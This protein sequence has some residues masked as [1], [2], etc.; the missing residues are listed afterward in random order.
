MDENEEGWS[1]WSDGKTGCMATAGRG[2]SIFMI[3]LIFST[4]IVRRKFK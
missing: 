4:L 3:L 1:E 2:S